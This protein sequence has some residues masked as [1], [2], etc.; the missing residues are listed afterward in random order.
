MGSLISKI[1]NLFVKE[2][3]P[4]EKAIVRINNKNKNS[5]FNTTNYA[6]TNAQLNKLF[7]F[8][9]DETMRIPTTMKTGLLNPTQIIIN[10]RIEEH[11]TL[12]SCFAGF[13]AKS[14]SELMEHLKTYSSSSGNP[15]LTHPEKYN[16]NYSISGNE[17]IAPIK[18]VPKM[19]ANSIMNKAVQTRGVISC[20][21]FPGIFSAT[22]FVS[23]RPIPRSNR[24]K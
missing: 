22:N 3:L 15:D 19:P 1:Y 12:N 4:I 2:L 16:F 6:L 17:E 10:N 7:Q 9:K 18:I 14:Y 23:A 8:F 11:Y 13:I 5:I 20:E 24:P 21:L